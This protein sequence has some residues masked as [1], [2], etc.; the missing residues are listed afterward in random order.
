MKYGYQSSDT[1]YYASQ[2]MLMINLD[3]IKSMKVIYV[4]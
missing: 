4:I 1:H 2:R 3:V